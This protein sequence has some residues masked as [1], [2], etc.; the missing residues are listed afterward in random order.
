MII[1]VKVKMLDFLIVGGGIS[2]ICAA[3]E[4]QKKDKKFLIINDSKLNSSSKIAAG[5]YN[6]LLPKHI[7]TAYNADI[8]YPQVAHFYTQLEEYANAKFHYNT[9]IYYI[10]KTMA[11]QNNWAI[12]LQQEKFKAFGEIKNN[13]LTD[14]ESP[15]GYLKINFSGRIDTEKMIETVH[16][17]LHFEKKI[18]DENFDINNLNYVEHNISYNTIKAKNILFCQGNFAPQNLKLKPA[19]GEIITL[20]F[21]LSDYGYDFI[22]QQGVFL[23]QNNDKTYKTGSTFEWQNLDNLPSEKGKTEILEKLKFWH[24]GNFEILDHVAGIRPSSHDRRPLV[25]KIPNQKNAYI[26]NG[27]GSKGLALAPHYAAMLV[28]SVY[29]NTPIDHEVDVARIF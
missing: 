6:P 15:F 25:G 20:K 21:N 24:T 4:L 19:K 23:T 26:L 12:A 16:K 18:L 8:I 14:I 5:I 17:K 3:F 22:P 11:E 28:N 27:M 9:P 13:L 7:K 1:F 10:F 2:G 29:N